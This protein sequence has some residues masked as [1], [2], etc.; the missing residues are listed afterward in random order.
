SSTTADE[1]RL[2][3]RR[4][5]LAAVGRVD[6]VAPRRDLPRGTAADQ[7]ER[8]PARVALCGR[9]VA[10]R[11]TRN[12]DVLQAQLPLAIGKCHRGTDAADVVQGYRMHRPAILAFLEE[13]AAIL[14]DHHAC[15]LYRTIW[16]AHVGVLGEEVAEPVRVHLPPEIAEAVADRA[17]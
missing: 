16:M 7:H 11:R 14:A 17:N 13:L 8:A 2:L 10:R 1:S 4:R 3:E 5:N 12:R 9:Q 15:F 6:G